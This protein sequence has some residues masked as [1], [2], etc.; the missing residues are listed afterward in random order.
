[1]SKDQTP[2]RFKLMRDVDESGV[3]GTGHVA[4]GVVFW[5]GK[6]VLCWRTNYNSV[7]VYD[8]LHTLRQ[9]HEHGGKTKVVWI[10]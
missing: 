10:D 7:A 4:D 1:M 8:N 2:M 3:S 5:N 6:C 9:I